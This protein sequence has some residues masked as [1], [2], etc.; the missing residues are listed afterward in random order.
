[1]KVY[2]GCYF[3]Q[4]LDKNNP[5]TIQQIKL[6]KDGLIDGIQTVVHHPS[7]IPEAMGKI[8]SENLMEKL[9]HLPAG[10]NMLVHGGAESA[11]A[12]PGRRFDEF[13][14]YTKDGMPKGISW[15]DWTREVL[16]W[17]KIV[18]ETLTANGHGTGLSDGII[19][20]THPG[21]GYYIHDAEA[22]GWVIETFRTLGP[23]IALENVPPAV[24]AWIWE[25][26][27]RTPVNWPFRSYWGFGGTPDDMLE[28]LRAIGPDTLCL[29]DF[30]HL[31]AMSNQARFA[32]TANR[33]PS[34]L[35][36]LDRA[37]HDFMALPHAKICHYSGYQG[38]YPH[39]SHDFVH[40]KPPTSIQKAL[41]TM[42]AVCLE[43]RWDPNND[44]GARRAIDDFR[45]IID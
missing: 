7:R 35:G 41:C 31:I 28:L 9:T 17:S 16:Q 13:D 19:G 18:G 8:T 24:D 45:K 27:R 6:F 23:Q 39:D 38:D 20:V 12:D 26:F 37:V 4:L 22:R 21:Y 29:I 10:L 11:G 44:A 14:I 5:R 43:L 1:M 2:G 25:F 3:E 40:V 42:Q 33:V 36:D 32:I 15:A 34:H 30:T